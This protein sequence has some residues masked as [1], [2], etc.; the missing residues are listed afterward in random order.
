M[1]ID[2]AACNVLYCSL[3]YTDIVYRIDVCNVGQKE[4]K[5]RKGRRV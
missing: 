4:M 1:D 3:L 5:G 2:M